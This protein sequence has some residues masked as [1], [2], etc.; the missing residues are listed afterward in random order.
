LIGI[1]DLAAIL[2]VVSVGIYVLGLMG[3][4]VTIRLRLVDNIS[5]AWYAVSLLPRTVVAGHGVRIWLTWP[6]G[7]HSY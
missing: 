7:L 1:G 5:V 3:L 4:A 2:A 6:I